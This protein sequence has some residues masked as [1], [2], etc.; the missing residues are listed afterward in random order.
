MKGAVAGFAGAILLAAAPAA[1]QAYVFSGQTGSS[2][3]QP[4]PLQSSGDAVVWPD[5]EVQVGMTLNFDG[6][7]RSSA[8]DALLTSWNSVGTKLQFSESA[9]AGQPCGRTNDGV[10]AAGWRTRTCDGTAFGDALAITLMTYNFTGGRWEISD[11]DIIVDQ[12][13]SWIA[14]GEPAAGQ[15]DFHRVIIHEL[16]HVLGLDHP[17]DAGQDVDA[18]MNSHVSGIS[19]LQ[20]D[21]I[22]GL[23]YLYGANGSGSGNNSDSGDG[24][25]GGSGADGPLELLVLLGWAVRR[26]AARRR[27]V[28][29][30][31]G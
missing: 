17:D 21:D 22:Q 26:L 19:T 11:A 31:A 30:A 8:V 7:F 29:A 25:G 20:D 18:I 2:D 9:T 12:G 10:N 13:R 4:R 16:G 5:D 23:N 28:A 24:D 1:V 15:V 3:D 6:A 14:D 27:A